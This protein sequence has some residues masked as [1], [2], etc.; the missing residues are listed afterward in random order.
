M[1]DRIHLFRDRHFDVEF[2]PESDGGLCCLDA[3]SDH[4]RTRKNFLEILS[5]A[6]RHTDTAIPTETAVGSE[7][8]ISQTCETRKGLPPAS[9]SDDQPRHF[10]EA[11]RDQ[12]C[13][14]IRSQPEAVH[15]TCR[16]RNDVFYSSG[17]FYPDQIGVC[18]EPESRRRQFLLKK[19]PQLLVRGR[20]HERR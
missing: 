1:E 11:T 8:Q 16:D 14:R 4:T 12:S 7:Y 5:L 15:D 6:E 19:E 2:P 20:N 3:F 10:G 13:D 18:V 17:D 9:A